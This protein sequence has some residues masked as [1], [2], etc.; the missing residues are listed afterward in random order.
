MQKTKARRIDKPAFVWKPPSPKQEQILY[1]WTPESPHKDFAYF[2]AEGSVRCGK[3]A[4]ADFSFTNW[5]SFTYD[6]EEFALCSKTIGTAIRNQVRPLMKMLS[7]EP[8]YEV[9]FKRSQV[10]GPHLI[11]HQKE[12][13]HENIF[14]IYG[15]KDESSQ[16]LIQG[17]TLAGILFD[18][19]PLMPQSF[20]NQGLARL[21][22]EGAKAWFLNN[23]ETPTHPLYVETLDPFRDAGKLYF[24]H[25]TMDDNPALSDEARNRITSQWPVG[26]VLYRRYVLGERSAAEGR[27]FSFFDDKPEAGYVVDTVPANFIQFLLGF[28]YG[29]SN[30]F[31]AQ[32]WGLSGGVWYILDEFYWDSTK[33]K[34]TK[35]N[36]DYIN[37]LE[38]L[39]FWGGQRKHPEAVIVPPEEKKGF[40]TDL[41]KSPKSNFTSIKSADNEILP[42]IEDLITMF[43]IGRLKVFRKN[44]PVTIWGFMNL[45]WDPKAQERGK[46]MYIKGGSG[47]PDHVCDAGRYIGRR[48]AKELRRMGLIA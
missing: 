28:D 43:S 31:A 47:S 21:S 48:A 9:Q 13:D 29:V 7:I 14:W 22:V 27:V 32:L 1:W 45:L 5:A 25:L 46:D 39:S 11:V 36:I 37:D 30:P 35:T 38:R 3:T 33:E 44:C 17:K 16:D 4:L 19:P 40:E 8:S 12:L 15:G 20:I 23:P 18:E 2:E 41:K 42:G 34:R 6:Q 26:S 24:L 10:E